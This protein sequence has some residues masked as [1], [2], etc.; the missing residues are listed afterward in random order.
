MRETVRRAYG[1]IARSGGSCCGPRFPCGCTTHGIATTL[2]YDTNDL[3]GLPDGA[4]LGLSCGNPIM[5]ASLMPGEVVLDLGCGAGFDA[6]IAALRVGARGRVI[7]VDMTPEM[8]AKAREN[9]E[10]FARQHRLKNVEFRL[11]EIERLPV[12]DVSVDVVISNC[13]INLCTHQQQVWREM[14][15]VLKPGGRV[16][17]TDTGLL[18][19]IPRTLR[20]SAETLVG[21]IAGAVPVEETRRMA[22][23]VGFVQIEMRTD[24]RYGAYLSQGAMDNSVFRRL[25]AGHTLSD[26]VTGVMVS[27]VKPPTSRKQRRNT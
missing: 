20:T 22:R 13:V 23:A 19:P 16:A 12:A 9:A 11:G 4:N 1:A 14:F 8:L 24:A 21:C 5:L 26:F 27:A 17:V 25:P 6:F 3:R 18:R 2:G 15:R 7:G 10:R